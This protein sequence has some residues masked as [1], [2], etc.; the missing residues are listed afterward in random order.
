MR[1]TL[2]ALCLAFST[3]VAL[4][5]D[6]RFDVNVD[7]KPLGTHAFTLTD[8]GTG[9]RKLHSEAHF[10]YKIMFVEVYRY[11]HVADEIWRGD[12]LERLTTQTE[13]RGEV[14]KVSGAAATAGFVVDG[15]KGRVAL[16]RCVMTYAYWNPKMLEQT[17]LLNPQDG[18]WSPAK[19]TKTGRE[20]IAVRGAKVEADRYH[21]DAGKAAIDLW[22]SPAGDWLAL[23][24]FTP[25]GRIVDYRLH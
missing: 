6:W 18:D 13:E 1:R 23:R 17:H 24:S 8:D 10:S 16:P 3:T 25:E 4:A 12:C 14:T 22:Y 5:R 11:D 19:I 20:T 15:P 7:D 9:R 21:L 2:L